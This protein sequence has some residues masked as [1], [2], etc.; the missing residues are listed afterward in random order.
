[1]D[2]PDVPQWPYQLDHCKVPSEAAIPKVDTFQDLVLKRDADGRDLW[3]WIYGE[4]RAAILDGRLKPGMR[5]PSS[6]SLSVQYG[7]A[8]GTVV[9]AFEQLHAEGYVKTERGV[10]SRVSLQLPQVVTRVAPSRHISSRGISV[11]ARRALE[12]ATPLPLGQS[13][14]RAFRSYEPAI[15]QFPV[16]IWSRVASRVLRRAPRSLYGQGE[17]G[18]YMPLRKAIAEYVGSSRGVRCSASQVIITAGA[19]QALDL[20]CRL[21]LE[22]GNEAWMEDPGYPG[23]RQAMRAAGIKPISVPVDNEG[24]IVTMGR[25]LAAKAQLVYVTPSN[26]FPLGVT[27]SATRRMELI[28]WAMT[29]NAWIVED[30]YDA[31]YC[32]SGHPVASLH[33]LDRSGCVLYI[34]TFTKM[35]FNAL[36]LG[37]IV[38]PEQLIE[39]IELARSFIDRHPPT[40]DQAIL[41]EFILDGHFGHHVRKM[42][43]LYLER[44]QLLLELGRKHLSGVLE[45][46]EPESGMKTVGWLK[47]QR[48][49]A[50]AAKRAQS[51][52]LEVL[53]ISG[54][55]CEY[56]ARPGLMLGFA[57]C[58]EEEIRRGVHLLKSVLR[59]PERTLR[60]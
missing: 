20:L 10:G 31:E 7:V 25:E 50:S 13:I 8:R 51:V 60:R 28:Q 37:F 44:L 56:H 57:G 9:V 11:R 14:G 26:Q 46:Q 18:G 19:Q 22:E 49:D 40:L 23:A 39:P 59:E 24:L 5:L 12:G 42:R 29:N 21:L 30:E 35:L 47:D 6:R 36:R 45:I 41:A 43:N 58:H 17:S 48:S 15:D 54:F 53:P 16:E 34:G 38:V 4:V 2:H 55:S 27:M 32:Y 3:R 33:S 52:G 1:M